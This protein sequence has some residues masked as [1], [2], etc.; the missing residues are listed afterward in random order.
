MIDSFDS[1]PE[2]RWNPYADQPHN[3]ASREE[4]F[5]RHF[6]Y[7]GGYLRLLWANWLKAG[8]AL[9]RY[10]RFRRELHARPVPFSAPL[11]VAVSP[12][13]GRWARLLS[14]FREAGIRRTLVRIPS[15][16]RDRLDYYREFAARLHAEGLDVVL[17]LLQCRED[18]V[19][20]A[21]WREFLHL[22]FKNFS[23]RCRYFEI[24][25]AWN[26]TKW[27]VWDHR[28]YTQLAGEAAAAAA[29]FDIRMVGPAVIDFEFHLYP[30]VIKRVDF[31]KISSLLYV[32]RVGAPEN[33]QFGWNAVQKIVLLKAVADACSPNPTGIWI[34][35][36]NWPLKGT[37]KYS[38]AAGKPNVS[39]ETQADYM[40][41]YMIPALC[42]GFVERMYWWQ[43][44][45]PGYGLIDPR[46]GGWRKRPA[47]Y[48]LKTLMDIL[49]G[50][51]FQK[52]TVAGRVHLYR[53]Q[54]DSRE[55]VA[56]WSE[57]SPARVEFSGKP[58]R[59]LSRDGE[60]IQRPGVG[61]ELSGSPKY[62][63]FDH[64]AMVKGLK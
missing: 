21:K 11:G 45:A 30:P 57:S 19:R 24:G 26:R 59:I 43:L 55:L 2:F 62:L 28:E 18:V 52:K 29:D 33:R 25:H 1:G 8:P 9:S 23:G 40:V 53:F 6:R 14:A 38:P 5:R 36:F 51:V 41:R 12:E 37:G 56:A 42:T 46:G 27:G 31:D 60:N 3:V 20:P 17:S 50:A 64:P 7:G 39:E 54:K 44:A 16:N 35:E 15:W 22:V 58:Q 63:F 10:F 48:A 34:T 61:I 32:D 4:R 47:F 49:P 13:S